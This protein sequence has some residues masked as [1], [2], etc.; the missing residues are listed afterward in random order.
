M[1]IR[2]TLSVSTDNKPYGVDDENNAILMPEDFRKT[3]IT[4]IENGNFNN[5]DTFEVDVDKNNKPIRRS[6]DSTVAIHRLVEKKYSREDFVIL[7]EKAVSMI[8]DGKEVDVDLL[9]PKE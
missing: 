9:L 6:V 7:L 3:V 8:E 2:L 1:R 4:S 5:G